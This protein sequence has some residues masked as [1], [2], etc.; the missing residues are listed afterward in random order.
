MGPNVGLVGTVE[1]RRD[2]LDE[3]GEMEGLTDGRGDGR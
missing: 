3:V 1:G 2:G